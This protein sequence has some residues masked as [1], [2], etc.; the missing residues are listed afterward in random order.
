MNLK[1]PKEKAVS[2]LRKR[3]G[4]L[5][6]HDFQPQ[7]WKN[8]TENDLKEIFP[9]GDL[10]WAQVNRIDFHSYIREEQA[11]T[12]REGKIQAHQLIESYIEQIEEYG[13]INEEQNLIKEESYQSKYS[14]LLDK[15]NEL[16]P[17]FN[18]LLAEKDEFLADTESKNHTIERQAAELQ[19]LAKNN[20]QLDNISVSKLF[21]LINNLPFAQF[22]SL[23]GGSIALLGASFYLGSQVILVKTDYDINSLKKTNDEQLAKIKSLKGQE[24][25]FNDSIDRLI[26]YSDSLLSRINSLEATRQPEKGQKES[27][28][29]RLQL[30]Y[31]SPKSIFNGTVLVIAE[32]GILT[33]PIE[34]KGATG[35]S[36]DKKSFDSQIIEVKKGD[37]F[38][39]MTNDDMYLVNVLVASSLN[40]E[41][42]FRHLKN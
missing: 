1:I 12:L 20:I 21:R 34:F 31:G 19:R 39:L 32:K 30:S 11:Q 41:L 6:S 33:S 26:V 35:V 13:R 29:F 2:I 38:F 18:A 10:K 9:P 27:T 28:T 8:K 40:I 17:S 7:V 5:S 4:D 42:E 14:E 24:A 22:W 23:I 3:I 16:V 37:Q 25:A 36:H 15:W